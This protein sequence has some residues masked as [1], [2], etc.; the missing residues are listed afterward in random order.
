MGVLQGFG[1]LNEIIT[2][3]KVQK[4]IPLWNPLLVYMQLAVKNQLI[5]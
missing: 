5:S 1:E 4:G 2:N 3:H